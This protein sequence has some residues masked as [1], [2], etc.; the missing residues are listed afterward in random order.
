MQVELFNVYPGRHTAHT[1]VDE[2]TEHPG[3]AVQLMHELPVELTES[4][5]LQVIQKLFKEHWMQLDILQLIQMPFE[6]TT[7]GDAH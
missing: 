2:Q 1:L 6:L 3:I 5:L 7:R 4:P